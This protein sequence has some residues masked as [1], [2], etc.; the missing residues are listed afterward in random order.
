[1][2]TPSTPEVSVPPGAERPQVLLTGATGFI[3]RNLHPVLAKLGYRVI[4]GSRNPER[5]RQAM[6]GH[7][8]RHLDVTDLASTQA[9]MEGCQ[10]AFYLVHAM[11]GG[12]GY[13]DVER[14]SA[15][16]FRVAAERAGVSRIIYLGGIRPNG[17]PSRHLESRLRTGEL[18]RAG[19]VT[20]LELQASMV[21]GGGSESWR[22]VRDLA[23]RLP[24][25]ILPQ[26]LENESQPIAIDDVTFALARALELPFD[27]SQVLPLPGP[28]AL[29]GREILLRTAHL[30]GSHPR[31][32]RVPIV[33]PKLSSYWITL[34]TR[35]DQ[36]ISEELV[37]GLR[38]N[39]LAGDEGF[40][41]LAPEYRRTPFDE[42]ARA[43]LLEEQSELS[44]RSRLAEM[45]IR[46]LALGSIKRVNRGSP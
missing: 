5:A 26:W 37:E 43:A 2:S 42:A 35:A 22:I 13:A 25:M 17:T 40:W 30:L 38:C 6:P 44:L 41:R 39:L 33:T 32:L 34:V 36:R 9:A 28:E 12:R 19:H 3:G 31:T 27:R 45:V 8:F 23:A 21:I 11:A 15:V 20:T 4:S 1:M 18:L 29:S 46:T 16:A 7:E 10:A 24:I 14:R